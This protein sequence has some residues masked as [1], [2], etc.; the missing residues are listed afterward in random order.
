MKIRT[1]YASRKQ[2]RSW[3]SDNDTMAYSFYNSKTGEYQIMLPYRASTKTRLHELAHVLLGH[4]DKPPDYTD[5]LIRNEIQ[6][7]IW[8]YQ[9]CDKQITLDA[10]LNIA[11][12]AIQWKDKPNFVFNQIVNTLNSN[13]IVLN[14]QRRSNLWHEIRA[15]EK[16]GEDL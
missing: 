2:I 11:A 10:M 16:L 13:G 14:K 5:E 3:D 12:L 4:C 6:A 1:L 7:E 8:A 9:K 15:L